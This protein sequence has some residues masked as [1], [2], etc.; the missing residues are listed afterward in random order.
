[1]ETI[2]AMKSTFAPTIS[3]ADI[4]MLNAC[5]NPQNPKGVMPTMP[6]AMI[7]IATVIT[8]TNKI[9]T[10][11]TT[12]I[13]ETTSNATTIIQMLSAPKGRKPPTTRSF[14]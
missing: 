6:T 14:Q 5:C 3:S 2:A 8:T 13:V 12:R 9:A 4:Q 11:K 10:T 7:R 1:M